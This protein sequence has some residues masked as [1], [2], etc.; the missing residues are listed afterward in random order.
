MN[1]T[2]CPQYTIK[3]EVNKFR[4]SK[5]QKKVLKRVHK[6][7]NVDV[8]PGGQKGENCDNIDADEHV[9]METV[10]DTKMNPSEN[11]SLSDDSPGIPMA[12]S[13]DVTSPSEE[14]KT[15]ASTAKSTNPTSFQGKMN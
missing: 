13:T 14:S 9:S 3:C 7:L 10:V 4:L 2:C 5:S 8:K 1:K 15:A 12:S 6:Y 11:V